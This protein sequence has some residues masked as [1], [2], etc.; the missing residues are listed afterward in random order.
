MCTLSTSTMHTLEVGISV[1]PSV[2]TSTP[3]IDEAMI[4]SESVLRSREYLVLLQ[5]CCSFVKKKKVDECAS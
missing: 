5:H 2:S 4:Y 3:A 1:A